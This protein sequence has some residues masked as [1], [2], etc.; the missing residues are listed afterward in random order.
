MSPE[1]VASEWV[2]VERY[3]TQYIDISERQKRL[4][5]LYRRACKIPP[6]LKPIKS[7]DFQDDGKFAESFRILLATIKDEPL[8][9]GEQT[10]SAPVVSLPPAIPRRPAVGFVQRHDEHKQ[11]ILE[12]LKR[13]LTPE[14]NQLVVLWGRGGAGKTTL[15]AEAV[16]ASGETFTDRIVWIN[17]LSHADLTLSTLL[18]EIAAQL[19]R[20]DLRPLPTEEKEE[21]VRALINAAPTLIVLDNFETI[22]LEEQKACVRFLAERA[23]CPALITTR[24]EINEDEVNNISLDRMLL[25]EAHDLFQRLI[26]R[27]R[28][29]KMFDTLNRNEI[30]Q[31]TEFNPLL[32]KWV[33]RQID[34][35]KNA[36]TALN[37]LAKGDTE[38]AER[39]FDRS[40]NLESVSDDSRAT[41][42]ALSLFVPD[43]S[44]E[45]LAEVAGFG[46]D[47]LRLDKAVE[48]LAAVW[49][50]DM[51]EGERLII[52]GLTYER[53]KARLSKDT[54]LDEFRQRFVAHFLN[55]AK[56][57][58][59]TTPED[60][61]ALEDE[62]DN[63]L[64]AMDTASDLEDWA[65]VVQTR[66][67]LDEFLDL[68][69]YWDEAI[70]SG[71]QALAAARHSQ[72]ESSVAAW[73]HNLA[74]IHQRRGELEAARRLYDESLE[75]EKKL[76]SQSGI[77][78]TLHQ[79][80]ILAQ[81]EGEIEEARRLYDESL[82][83]KKRLGN[84]SGIAST[85]H[86]LGRLAQ[87]EG[88]IEEARRLYDESLEIK[89]RLGNQ[90]GIASTLHNLAAIAQ[91]QGEIAEARRLYD[92]SLEI[93]KRLGNQSGIASTL[94]QLAIL[95]QAQGE[96]A[97]ARRLYDES[98]E[99]NE[100]LGNQ[101][102]IASTLHQL[103]R[104]AQAQGEIEEA[105]RLYDESLE[106]KKRLGNQS[107]IALSLHGLGRL[108]QDEGKVEEARRLYDESLEIEKRLGNQSGIA[109][110]LHQLGRLAE[111]GNNRVEAARLFRE[112]LSIFEKLKS[113][114][115]E[116][117]RR[118]LARV[119]AEAS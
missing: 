66:F 83:I 26:G 24:T 95:A 17:A 32:L 37:Y 85:L 40:F 76:G 7:V 71:Q 5:P 51:T 75:I 16:R 116:V 107:G 30:I 68:R 79:L 8:P 65:S 28:K 59:Q 25:E 63:V 91:A 77:A 94:H 117:A 103:G 108:A 112:A 20:P 36:E 31:Q 1:S 18:N 42:L 99:I 64:S 4:I 62:K 115:A 87:N 57:H 104:L 118:S 88:E 12:Q 119:G 50:I 72:N 38:V 101:S 78:I 35:A 67:A 110:T 23:P 52:Q 14:N 46:G 97:E 80:A 105:R 29:P 27:T 93:E 73:V 92:E 49:L 21:Q 43:A 2:N 84:Q 96:V 55:Y 13:E 34:L 11:N 53:A 10:S 102:G 48:G 47:L 15:A 41:L 98:L 69:G 114:D 109:S 22:K 70:R 74:I 86:Q 100:R 39:I 44:R 90:S 81:D 54:R 45:T 113:P 9:R 89:K 106:I 56:A 60:F 6:F 82:E 33:V 61:D 19:G 111:D 3:V 58:R